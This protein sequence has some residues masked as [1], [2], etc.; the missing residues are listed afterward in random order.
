M[1]HLLQ[2]L[3]GASRLTYA[4]VG[5]GLLTAF[6]YFK[7]FFKDSAT[8]AEDAENAAKM[9]W[10]RRWVCWYR[11]SQYDDYQW[12]QMKVL[13]WI[14]IS[15]GSGVGAYYQLPGWFPQLFRP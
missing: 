6:F 9:I 5:V 14:G 13:I 1:V 8:F 10:F 11:N 15:V 4:S 3:A 2:A 12:S 7:I